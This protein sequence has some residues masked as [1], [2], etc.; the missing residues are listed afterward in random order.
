MIETLD[1]PITGMTC[2]ACASR[3]ERQLVRAP[4]VRNAGVNLATN[5][6]TVEYDTSEIA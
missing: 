1:L 3:I 2:A 5:R 4:G 6:A